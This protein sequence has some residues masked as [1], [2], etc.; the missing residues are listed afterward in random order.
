MPDQK[1]TLE[2]ERQEPPTNA[3]SLKNTILAYV[4]DM[5]MGCASIALAGYLM[6]DSFRHAR[7]DY[8]ELATAGLL[9]FGV[10]FRLLWLLWRILKRRKCD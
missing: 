7:I 9:I 5:I 4:Y 3:P 6:R 10:L 1:P 8:Y 2:Y